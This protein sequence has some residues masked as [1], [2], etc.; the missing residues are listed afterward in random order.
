LN[1]KNIF[2]AELRKILTYK[3]ELLTDEKNMLYHCTDDVERLQKVIADTEQQFIGSLQQIKTLSEKDE[4]WQKELE[5]LSGA[6]QELVYMVDPPEEGEAGERPL[7]ERLRGALQKVVKF[8]SEAPVACVSHALA[9]IKSFVLEAQVETFAQGVAAECTEDQFTEYLR[10]ARPV[11]EQIVE[12][13][14][15]EKNVKTSTCFL[16]YIFY[17]MSLLMCLYLCVP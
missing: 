8:L 9:F 17:L 2:T 14:L 15:Q 16:V 4:R 13:V 6:A 5:D 1:S 7:L 11:E 10:E 3:E 12:N